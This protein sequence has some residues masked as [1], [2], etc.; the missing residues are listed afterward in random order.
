MKIRKERDVIIFSD[1]AGKSSCKPL[2]EPCKSPSP[3]TVGDPS[4]EQVHRA[5]LIEIHFSLALQTDFV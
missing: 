4:P 5:L 1:E 2:I 3:V